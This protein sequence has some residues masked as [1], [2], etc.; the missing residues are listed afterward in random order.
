MKLKRNIKENKEKLRSMIGKY[1]I[2]GLKKYHPQLFLQ[3]LEH[4]NKTPEIK[5][6]NIL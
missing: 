4:Y 6:L 1:F 2:T 5:H 3:V